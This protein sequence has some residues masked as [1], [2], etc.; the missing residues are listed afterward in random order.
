MR[1]TILLLLSSLLL[2]CTS[3]SE[4]RQVLPV[5]QIQPT[6]FVAANYLKKPISV[7]L[8]NGTADFHN[9]DGV[10]AYEPIVFILKNG[11]AI[12]KALTKTGNNFFDS[13][14][15]ITLVYQNG[16]LY[17]DRLSPQNLSINYLGVPFALSEGWIQGET[18]TNVN[19]DGFSRLRD[20]N[21]T[22]RINQ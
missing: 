22:V 13:D 4:V 14:A 9:L 2:A 12:T 1:L 3:V 15:K 21:V 7:T 18:Y 19:T 6:N 16:L 20:A 8:A 11:D 10:S 17:V 5:Q